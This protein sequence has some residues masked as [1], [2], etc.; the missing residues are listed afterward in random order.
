M[1]I[2][3][4]P[5]RKS[6]KG[7]VVALGTFD[8]VHRGHQQVI[9]RAVKYANKIKA[10][11]LAMT[12][13]P[14]P[15]RFI[16]PQRGLRLLTTLKEREELFCD[17]GIDGV[18]VIKFRKYVQNLSY[19]NFVKKYLVGKLGVRK[20]FVGF[21]YAFGKG[22][23]GS[24]SNLKALGKKYGFEV[25][26]V[27]PVKAN[28]QPV[29]SR[30]IRELIGEGKFPKALRLLGHPYQV[31]GKVVR[32][33]GRGR[34]IGFPT[35][36]LKVDPQKLIPLQGVYAGKALGKKCAV[37]IGTRPTFGGGKVSI[38]VHILNFRKD[39]HGKT[40]TVNLTR[41]IRDEMQFSDAEQLKKQMRQ[42]IRRV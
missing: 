17:L 6:L 3:R 35:A 27:P 8:G 24:V 37:N 30:V 22:R 33:H 25:A 11:S 20:V 34:T 26:V 23:S 10:A 32:A 28:G 36:N 1:R 31:T 21:D 15:Q 18:V 7:S 4:H 14:H 12:F 5:K 38:E 16:V 42:D 19:E 29:K 2:I 40:I 39:I 9:K 13:D 41:R